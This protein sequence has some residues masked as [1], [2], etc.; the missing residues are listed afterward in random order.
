[1]STVTLLHPGV[2]FQLPPVTENGPKKSSVPG[3][4]QVLEPEISPAR[5]NISDILTVSFPP[6]NHRFSRF[7]SFIQ[8]VR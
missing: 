8:Q 2:V 5:K 7:Y 3:D 6:P 4:Q 1:V